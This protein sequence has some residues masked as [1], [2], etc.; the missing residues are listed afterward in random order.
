[1]NDLSLHHPPPPLSSPVTRDDPLPPI[2]HE[3]TDTLSV[4]PPPPKV[5]LL[6]PSFDRRIS[7]S[8]SL[9]QLLPHPSMQ[10]CTF[11][12][13]DCYHSFDAVAPLVLTIP[14]TPTTPLSPNTP[15]NN[16]NKPKKA[17][18]LNDL[19]DTEKQYVDQLTGVI[20]V[21]HHH[22]HGFQPI[23]H[24]GILESRCRLVSK[25]PPSS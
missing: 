15:L 22:L 10:V 9:L 4:P 2:P 8:L 24:L 12:H 25:Q 18:P 14:L 13:P 3:P 7:F 23:A 1:M 20:R 21:S 5:F 17:N 16:E 19:I 11:L 6:P